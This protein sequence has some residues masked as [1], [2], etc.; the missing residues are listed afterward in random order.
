MRLDSSML[1]AVRFDIMLA[2]TGDASKAPSI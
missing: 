1:S 2:I